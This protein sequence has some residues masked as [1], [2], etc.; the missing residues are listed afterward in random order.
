MAAESDFP[1]GVAGMLLKEGIKEVDG[2]LGVFCVMDQ[3]EGN[4]QHLLN[5]FLSNNIYTSVREA[6]VLSRQPRC[7]N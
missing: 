5:L 7:I 2:C 1:G 4:T 3:I 6:K